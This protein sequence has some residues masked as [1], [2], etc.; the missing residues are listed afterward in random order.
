MSNV[1]HEPTVSVTVTPLAELPNALLANHQPDFILP[2]DAQLEELEELEDTTTGARPDLESGTR[3]VVPALDIEHAEVEDD[4]RKW[5]PLR[6][7][8]VLLTI[9]GAATISGL[10]GNIYNPGIAQIEDQLHATPAQI[11]WSLSI[12]ILI[13]GS[14]PLL[15]SAISEIIGRKKVYLVS[16]SIGLVGAIVAATARSI[17]VLIAMRCLQ[18]I[19]TAAILSIGAAT[20]ADIYDPH[21][22]GTMMGIYYCAPLIGPA[23]GPILGGALTQGFNWRA[24]FWFL[25]IVIG[26]VLVVFVFFKDTFRRERSLTYQR[27]LQR[28]KAQQLAAQRSETSTLSHITAVEKKPP[29]LFGK[30]LFVEDDDEKKPSRD[31]PD[32]LETRAAVEDV[33]AEVKEIKLSLT[34][35]NPVPPMLNV[36][37]RLNNVAILACSGILFGVTYSISYTCSITLG[38]KYHYNAMEIGLV[39]LSFG[40]GNMLG[41][42]LGGRYSDYILRRMREKNGGK[43]EAEMRLASTK[44]F[45]PMIPISI[46]AYGWMSERHV[47]IGGICVILFIIGFFLIAVYASTLAYI[48][49]ANVG[50]SSSAVA[51]NSLFRG[52]LAFMSAEI[53]VPLQ[54]S[55]GDGGLYSVWA[56]ITLLALLALLLVIW[57]GAEWRQSAI[58]R[59]NR[60]LQE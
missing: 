50:R 35:V 10:G 3:H 24:T 30:K 48:V 31:S 23:L 36:L 22:R 43:T 32:V 16:L 21:E 37:S 40:C 58:E 46:A 13:Q 41:S 7:W 5:S 11:S 6:K 18:A 47:N 9:S 19:G 57:K 33:T 52:G 60:R 53:A 15:W 56:G 17:S 39:L 59:E 34:D 12:F 29:R 20:L 44:W 26:S 2:V 45:L 49:D 4:P 55:I 51:C 14:V 8:I 27:V 1:L 54:N 38:K 28:V 42:I 25:S